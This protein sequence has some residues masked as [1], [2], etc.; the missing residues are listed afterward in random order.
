MEQRLLQGLKEIS[1]AI[2]WD[3]VGDTKDI[4]EISDRLLSASL[5]KPIFEDVQLLDMKHSED[6]PYS[7]QLIFKFYDELGISR[8]FMGAPTEHIVWRLITTPYAISKYDQDLD[9]HI[10][11]DEDVFDWYSRF[12]VELYDIAIGE[13]DTFEKMMAFYFPQI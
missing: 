6:V 5:K 7:Y 8:D 2:I 11:E 3:I 1:L 10:G 9:L 13:Q 12:T 4:F